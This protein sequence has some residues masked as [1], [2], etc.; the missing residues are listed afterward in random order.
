[1]TA[2]VAQREARHSPKGALYHYSKYQMHFFC[3]IQNFYVPPAGLFSRSRVRGTQG[4]CLYTTAQV[5]ILAVL[6]GACS[7]RS[8]PR[9][10]ASNR[11]IAFRPARANQVHANLQN[12]IF[13]TSLLLFLKRHS[14]C[15]WVG[16]HGTTAAPQAFPFVTATKRC[17]CVWVCQ[18]ACVCVSRSYSRINRNQEHSSLKNRGD[19][20]LFW[21]FFIF[22]MLSAAAASVCLYVS[23]LK[24][25]ALR[26]PR[27]KSSHTSRSSFCGSYERWF[28]VRECVCAHYVG[29]PSCTQRGTIRTTLRLNFK[30][31]AQYSSGTTAA[32]AV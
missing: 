32:A 19:I 24:L 5:W 25:L 20:Q 13:F 3:G 29:V 30:S 7:G 18:R 12:V 16:S 17:F 23:H 22:A 14:N 15:Q 9:N 21:L 2:C 10:L 31:N 8:K 11:G 26:Q 6:R 28:C 27:C 4:A 1:M